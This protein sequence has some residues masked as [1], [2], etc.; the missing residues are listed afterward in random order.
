MGANSDRISLRIAEDSFVIVVCLCIEELFVD[1]VV[2]AYTGR[3]KA[4]NKIRN[5]MQLVTQT[6]ID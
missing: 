1:L 4:I 5:V 3:D 6:G 2:N